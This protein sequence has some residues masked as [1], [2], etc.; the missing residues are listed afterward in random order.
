MDHIYTAFWFN[1]LLFLFGA[2]LLSCTFTTQLPSLK[3]FRLWNFLKARQQFNTLSQNSVVDNNFSNS[4]MYGLHESNFHLFRQGKKNY[5]YSGLL[6]RVGPIIVHI[7]IMMLLI[8][9]TLGS[10]SGY[11]A[12]Q[13]VPRGE[14]FHLQNIYQLFSEI[15]IMRIILNYDRN[16]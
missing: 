3:K 5:A 8:G 13:I 15:N 7:S 10:F 14:I 1:I 16:Y 6:G 4:V 2:S 11:T 9:S 12:Q